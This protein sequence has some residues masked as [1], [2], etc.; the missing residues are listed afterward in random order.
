MSIA[1]MEHITFSFEVKG[2][3]FST[4]II[5]ALFPTSFLSFSSPHKDRHLIVIETF[6]KM[7]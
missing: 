3:D 2:Q 5:P 4:S 7:S 6:K 1:V